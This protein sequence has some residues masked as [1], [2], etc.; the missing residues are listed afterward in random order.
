[1]KKILFVMILFTGVFLSVVYFPEIDGS[2]LVSAQEQSNQ[3]SI[4]KIT[5]QPTK[6]KLKL[7]GAA[8]LDDL[9]YC[10]EDLE[11]FAVP[12]DGGALFSFKYVYLEFV[13]KQ[14]GVNP[15]LYLVDEKGNPNAFAFS[16]DPTSPDGGI[17][18]GKKLSTLE[19]K[20]FDIEHSQ[21]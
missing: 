7:I 13:K 19:T 5:M 4:T 10:F 8:G 16:D 11:D 14:A 2:L 20:F 15:T 3:P 21:H 12:N 17:V 6:K 1:M 18:I 9:D